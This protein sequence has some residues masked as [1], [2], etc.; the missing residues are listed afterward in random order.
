MIA[1]PGTATSQ[2]WHGE[3][4]IADT[5]RRGPE[6]KLESTD[7]R[8][9]FSRW[10]Q[11]VG[12][13]ALP[14]LPDPIFVVQLGGKTN[15][16]MWDRDGWSDSTSYPG[17]ATI[18]PATMQTRWLVDGE[19]DVVTLSIDSDDLRSASVLDQFSQLRF[20]FNDPLGTA[21]SRQILAELYEPESGARDIYVSSLIDAL[22]AHMLRGPAKTTEME[23]PVSAFSSYRIHHLMNAIREHPEAEHSLEDM[24][25]QAGIT[26]SHL[27]RVFRRATN[28]T[29][30]QFVLKTRLERAQQ[31]LSQSDA[32]MNSIAELLGFSSQSSFNRAFR[33]FTGETP[34]FYRNRRDAGF[35]AGGE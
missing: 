2:R 13:Y 6:V 21:L 28:L 27:C 20:A 29:P 11:F 4:I 23:F 5:L 30:H 35:P 34:S 18:V 8:W 9:R 17:S 31:L 24:A 16:R 32:P 3:A 33:K 15:V 25:M 19:L 10:R 26:P 1:A 14:G 12:S 22:K 7:G